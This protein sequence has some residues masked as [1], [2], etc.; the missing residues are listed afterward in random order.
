MSSPMPIADSVAATVIM[1]KVKTCATLFIIKLINIKFKLIP[2][3]INSIH[4]NKINKLRLLQKVPI[5][6]HK[7]ILNEKLNRNKKLK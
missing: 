3:N 4:N 6:P 7:N 2:N 1:N 5:K